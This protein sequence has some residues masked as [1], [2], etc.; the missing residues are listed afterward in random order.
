MKSETSLRAYAQGK[1]DMVHDYLR[2]ELH[3]ILKIAKGKPELRE[4]REELW[5]ALREI[6]KLTQVCVR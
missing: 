4:F 3:A 5:D 6:R 2:T 1:R